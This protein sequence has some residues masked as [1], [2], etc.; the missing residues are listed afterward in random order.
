MW[1]KTQVKE[2]NTAFT[3]ALI[4]RDRPSQCEMRNVKWERLS[5]GWVK[6]N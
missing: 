5:Q 2:I 1:I 6:L 4:M 3:K